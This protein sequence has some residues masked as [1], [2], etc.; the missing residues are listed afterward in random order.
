MYDITGKGLLL[1]QPAR[2]LL[3]VPAEKHCEEHCDQGILGCI[4]TIIQLHI[5]SGARMPRFPHPSPHGHFSLV[6]TVD[7]P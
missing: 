6:D 5:N 1:L 7:C 3:Q 4:A 2:L